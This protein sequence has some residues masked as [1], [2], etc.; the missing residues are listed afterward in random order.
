MENKLFLSDDD[1]E[2]KRL[3]KSFFTNISKGIEES[4]FQ[5]AYPTDKYDH[6]EKGMVENWIRET[7]EATGGEIVKGSFNDNE[8]TH[9]ILEG[10]KLQVSL[11]KAMTVVDEYGTV[12]EMFVLPKQEVPVVTEVDEA[13]NTLEKG[14]DSEALEK[15]KISDALYYGDLKITFSKT[16]KEIKEKLLGIKA[17]ENVKLTDIKRNLEAVEDLLSYKPTE[18]GYDCSDDDAYRTFKWDMTYIPETPSSNNVVQFSDT[19]SGTLSKENCELNRRWNDSVYAFREIK[20]EIDT[21]ELL[22][23]NI[24]D[25]KKYELTARQ[26]MNFGF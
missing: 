12:K 10:M 18:K 19:E 14:R 20:K 6:F 5:S 11:L 7:Y 22:E 4:K 21:I 3:N 13:I 24:E 1:F 25:N 2:N 16:G 9:K 26:M 8:D 23:N 17:S 15:G